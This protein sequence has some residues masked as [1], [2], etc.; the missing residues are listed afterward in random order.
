[1]VTAMR[2]GL[3]GVGLAAV[4]VMCGAPCASATGWRLEGP[5]GRFTVVGELVEGSDLSGVAAISETHCLLGSDETRVVQTA[6]IDRTRQQLVIEQTV[7]LVAE[8]GK[9]EFDIEGVT[10]A[11]S[12]ATGQPSREPVRRRSLAGFLEQND[13]LRPYTRRP[14]QQR[15]INFEGLAAKDGR[16]YLGARAPSLEGS[17]FVIELAGF[18]TAGEKL[19]RV[20]LGPGLGIRELT[21]L[22]QGFLI[23]AGNSGA[24][25][26]EQFPRALDYREDLGFSLYFWPGPEASP[27]KISD[28]PPLPGKAEG[29]LVLGE[30]EQEIDMLILFDGPKD[31]QPTRFRV[32]KGDA[33]EASAKR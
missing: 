17:T 26:N 8:R 33:T 29:L 2:T 20:A 13:V 7:P 19:H 6:R 1:M 15:G 12:E 14:L 18:G 23:I 32:V 5:T 4:V 9:T 28:L 11:A 22:S 31:G 27:K 21:A 30:S 3:I 16:L 10:A 25:P 24:E